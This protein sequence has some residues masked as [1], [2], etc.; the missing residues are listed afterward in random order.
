MKRRRSGFTLIEILIALSI[1][2]VI[3]G[4][5][6]GTYAATVQSVSR[7]RTRNISQQQARTLLA[8]MARELRCSRQTPSRRQHAG[9]A[10]EAGKAP[11]A[12][13]VPEE[14]VPDFFGQDG[15]SGGVLLQFTSAGGIKGWESRSGGLS[16]IAY[17]LDGSSGTLSRRQSVAAAGDAADEGTWLAIAGGVRAI[18]LRY[19][20][21]EEWRHQWDSTR[22]G[23]LPRAVRIEVKFGGH[24][25]GE[26]AFATAV[27]VSCQ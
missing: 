22:E 15:S 13:A 8:M 18:G 10:P 5:V 27:H 2:V 20:D 19:F 3:L 4:L 9:K 16:R 26:I 24:G 25:K 23:E 12:G 11:G 7:C 1:I 14:H 6:Y 17:R 21:G